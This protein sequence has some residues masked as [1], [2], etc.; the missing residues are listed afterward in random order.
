MTNVYKGDCCY[1][2][3][4]SDIY[5]LRNANQRGNLQEEYFMLKDLIEGAV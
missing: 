2:L 5:F 3:V 4:F 1:L